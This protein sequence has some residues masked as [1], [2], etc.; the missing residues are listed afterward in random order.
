MIGDYTIYNIAKEWKNNKEL[1]SYIKGNKFEG[2][3]YGHHG[4]DESS[5]SSCQ[6]IM[7]LDLSLFILVSIVVLLVW[8]FAFWSVWKFWDKLPEW[9]KIVSLIFLL[10]PSSGGPLLTLLVVYFSKNDK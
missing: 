1:H 8:V 6:K 2:Y 9:A 10:S 5:S 7:G 4:N 3:R